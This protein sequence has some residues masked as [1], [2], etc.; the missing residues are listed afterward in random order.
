M[1]ATVTSTIFAAFPRKR[2]NTFDVGPME[3][4]PFGSLGQ[5]MM[6]L[7]D[8][9]IQ[10]ITLDSH[11]LVD[12]HAKLTNFINELKPKTPKRKGKKRRRK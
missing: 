10:P 7:P 1:M 12:L 3:F 11:D 5:V 6:V 9:E 2:P 8:Y 4:H